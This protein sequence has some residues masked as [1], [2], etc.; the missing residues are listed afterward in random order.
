MRPTPL[1]GARG[2]FTLIELLVVIAIIAILIGLLIPAVQAVREAA[3]RTQCT[4]NLKQMGLA[5]HNFH[6]TYKQFPAISS[7]GGRSIFRVLLPYLEQG[8][9]VQSSSGLITNTTDAT[10][11]A[12]DVTYANAPPLKIFVCPTRRGTAQAW[13]DYAGAFTPLQQVPAND[14]FSN[15]YSLLDSPGGGLTLAKIAAKDGTSN[16]LFLAHRF[17]QPQNYDNINVPPQSAYDKASTWD[18]GWAACE[19]QIN[20]VNVFQPVRPTTATQQTTRSN[21][22]SHRFTTGM[23]RDVNHNMDWKANP[24]SATGYPVRTNI[25]ANQS[26]GHEG[27]HG[28]P[29]PG[30]SPCVWGDASVRPL[31]YG[32]DGRTLCALWG[33][34]DGVTLPNLD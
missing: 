24:G 19:G 15:T 11:F 16:T 6:D 5:W 12:N 29:H 7:N 20:G 23:L 30:S 26:I 3:N 1:R 2:G 22:E 34:N 33:W 9:M 32:L 4:N 10:S 17:V 28:G 31:R 21:H 18:A 27:I 25:A 14:Q 13:C 8:V